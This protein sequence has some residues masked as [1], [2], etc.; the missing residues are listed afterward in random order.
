MATNS[1]RNLTIHAALAT[2]GLT[3][4]AYADNPAEKAPV[5]STKSVALHYDRNASDGDRD[6][7]VARIET[8]A[9]AVCGPMEVKDF[10]A[11]RLWKQCVDTAV[12]DAMQQLDRQQLARLRD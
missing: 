5:V 4:T 1:I 12:A 7:L 2:L 10:H 8:A 6:A 9:R 3:A 11:R